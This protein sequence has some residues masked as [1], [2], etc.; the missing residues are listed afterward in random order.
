MAITLALQHRVPRAALRSARRW[1]YVGDDP[2]FE[3]TG[4]ERVETADVTAALAR[5]LRGP[6]LDA[7]GRLSALNDSPEWWASHLA[8]KQ[9]YPSLFARVCG[10]AAGRELAD[11]GTLIVCSTPAQLTELQREL[12]G[13]R[14]EGFA[15]AALRRRAPADAL[16][17][18][19]P[20]LRLLGERAPD[21]RPRP[22]HRRRHTGALCA[23]ANSGPPP[24]G[25]GGT[26]C[27]A[28]A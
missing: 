8:A 21:A 26:R 2:T 14:A 11:D 18:A 15:G 5:E 12:P 28:P 9:P 7:I 4:L 23:R 13:A 20:A 1:L 16:R 25:A 10:L 17:L 24:A 22:D 19:W 3:L 27:D 6:Y